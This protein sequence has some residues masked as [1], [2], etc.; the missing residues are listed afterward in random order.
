[1]T[2]ARDTFLIDATG[3]FEASHKAFLGARLLIVDDED[4]TVVFGVIRNLL[5]LRHSLGIDRGL[6]VIGEEA[7]GVTSRTNIQK[8][9]AFLQQ[10]G[11]RVVHDPLTRVVDL[12]LRFASVATGLVTHDRRLLLFATEGRR[13]ILL[14]GAESEVY[15]VDAVKSKFGVI[16]ALLPAFLA[17]TDGPRLT[18][19]TKREALAVLERPE[20][21]ATTIA[22]P[23]VIPSRDLRNRLTTNGAV[24]LQRLKL[25][26]CHR[27]TCALVRT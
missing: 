26:S 13:I 19:L 7:Y 25:S 16:L 21:L 9:A 4:C 12:S 14:S 17:L 2:D 24:I 8:T 27:V 6:V 3:L 18:V 20:D 5:H 1:M 22:D 10:L 15:T 11:I 23:S